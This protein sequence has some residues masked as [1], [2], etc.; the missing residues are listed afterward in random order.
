MRPPAY[1]DNIIIDGNNIGSYP[2]EFTRRKTIIIVGFGGYLLPTQEHYFCIGPYNGYFTQY[3][4]YG[5]KFEILDPQISRKTPAPK[6]HLIMGVQASGKTTI[7]KRFLDSN[8]NVPYVCSDLYWP[9]DET[10]RRCWF[11][12]EG[13]QRCWY[14]DPLPEDQKARAYSW[15]HKELNKYM[16]E[17]NDVVFEGTLVDK[18]NR[19]S[20]MFDAWLCGYEVHGKFLIPPLLT[21][22]LRN[23][24]RTHPVPDI[25]L[26]RTYSK[27]CIPEIQE[28]FTTLEVLRNEQEEEEE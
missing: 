24:A 10:G 20:I 2:L 26:A 4:D 22:A 28:G 6:L 23:A 9:V 11:D 14:S 15:A 5:F 18:H 1:T 25:A 12:E 16:G 19:N 21:C 3:K 17:G 27:V 13:R 7:S 8:P